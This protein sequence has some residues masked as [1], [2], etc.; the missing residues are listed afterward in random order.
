MS[1]RR[2]LNARNEPKRA[3]V[4]NEERRP[5]RQRDPDANRRDDQVRLGVVTVLQRVIPRVERLDDGCGH[6][7]HHDDHAENAPH[8]H[9]Y[10]CIT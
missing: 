8:T 10:D 2:G 5:K 7:N 3:D 9:I 4:T 6:A 1:R